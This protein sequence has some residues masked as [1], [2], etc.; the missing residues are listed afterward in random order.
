MEIHLIGKPK[1]LAGDGTERPVPGHQPWA[2]LARLL[3]T[4]GA[5]GRRELAAEVF[6]DVEDPLGA[7]RWCLAS[8][9]KATGA[10][11]LQGDPITLNFPPGTSVDV[12][13]IESG[14]AAETGSTKFLEG[15]EPSTNAEFET[16][17]MIEREHIA[18]ALFARLRREAMRALSAGAH[19]RAKA[20]AERAVTC[21]PLDESGHIVLVKCMATS[22]DIAAAVAHV[23]ATEERI[24][25]ETGE[26]PSP[27]LRGAA[28][29]SFAD[30]P[31]GLSKAATIDALIKSGKAA[32]SAGA[33]DAGLDCLRRAAEDADKSGERHLLASALLEL[34]TSLVHAVR[35]FDDEG[36]LALQHAA[37]IAS[38]IGSS[39]IGAKAL[40][41]LGYSEA[42][43]GRRPSAACYL[44]KAMAFA[45]GNDD[46]LASIKA[47]TGFNLV[48][49]GQ[50]EQGVSHY[51]QALE[52]A[53]IADNRRR[54][55]WTLGIGAWG[56]L[57]AGRPEEARDWLIKCLD[58][59][60]DVRW[61]A[62]RPWAVAL[63]AEVKMALHEIGNSTQSDLQEALA[64]SNQLGDPCWQ[65]AAARSLA[66]FH[67]DAKNYE[68][69]R[70]WLA[71]ARER[72]CS[73]TD[74][75][76]GLLV[77]ILVD[78]VRL[79]KLCGE[80]KEA[81][82]LARDLLPVVARTHADAHLGFATSILN[83]SASV[84]RPSLRLV[85]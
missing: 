68:N 40:C 18:S 22:G 11:T 33:V 82:M 23:D 19:N 46:C 53:R 85:Q 84:E 16:W 14:D 10:E 20:L 34:G 26:K 6:A 48:D 70:K 9:R 25:R 4:K 32:V 31:L 35:G 78:Q 2:V 55:I 28:R 80:D 30:A 29:K 64:L 51:Y 24:L 63:L 71:H 43:A 49:W 66:L 38:D 3:C 12:W 81:A 60:D 73:V 44:D 74:L 50:I 67:S 8:L 36:A 65:A 72:C 15:V 76:A 59:C 27:A 42:L 58:M 56:V 69:A 57:R 1:I 75:Y 47:F 77:E 7:L 13:N 21:R 83:E 39:E 79:A 45:Q 54:E 41:E 61:L 52:H 17:L 37:D 5:L 62:F